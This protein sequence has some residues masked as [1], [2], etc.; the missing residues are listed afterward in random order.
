MGVS[1]VTNSSAEIIKENMENKSVLPPVAIIGVLFFIFGFVTWMNGTLIP[2]LKLAC[3]LKTDA[4]AFFVT[5]AF[6]M[7]YFFLA[8]PSSAVLKL[9]GMKNGM[10]WGL[11]VMA[12]GALV[13]VPAANSR[14]FGLFLIGLFVQGMGLALLQTASNP[15]ISIIGPIESAAKRI[16]IMGICN[17]GAG[18]LSPIILSTIVLKNANELQD[19]I[20]A[21]SDTLTKENLLNELSGRII[22]PYIIM[23]IVLFIL[24]IMIRKSSLPDIDASKANAEP[25]GQTMATNKTS[26][27]QFPH[28]LLG[29]LCIFVYV[30]VEVMAGDAIG[31]YGKSFGIPLDEY[32]YFTS[33]TLGCMLVGYLI[34]ILT[35][36]KY[37]SQEKALRISAIVGVLFS[38]GAF[39]TK[40][41][42]SVGFVA[43][44]GLANALM[45]P[46]I[47]PL[48][49]NR[50][51]RFTERGSALLIM[52]I[53][54]GAVIP[55]LFG[56]LKATI[57]F[58]LVFLV[59]MLPCYLFI[60]YYATSG[61]KIK[62]MAG[63]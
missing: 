34:G 14:S 3:N 22:Y 8:I 39:A 43:A 12:V 9:T 31:I 16:S 54:G 35:I 41:Y 19:K 1:R 24:A 6:Y 62:R 7:A 58:Q 55:L 61:Y 15:Y 18:I 53:A 25:V 60:L 20:N 47:F 30:G 44:L 29:V 57:D 26:V 28:L 32:K 13:F 33:A 11:V 59:L 48:A 38:I 50:L 46:A 49:I 5:F 56:Y 23:A 4:E 45:W 21:A 27:L 2:F 10:S 37:I 40:G 17:K 42:V 51:G 52:G 36:P 63:Q